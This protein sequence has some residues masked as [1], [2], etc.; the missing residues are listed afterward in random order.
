MIRPTFEDRCTVSCGILHPELTY[1]MKAG[2]LNPRR[3]LFTPPGLHAFPE[4]L[5]K[6]LL[7][8]LAYAREWCSDNE[9]IVVYGKKRHVSTD[10]PRKRV[11]SILQE[12][13]Q[14]IVRVQGDYG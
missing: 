13:D 2:F 7:K 10:E 1:L 11:D 3:I 14:G 6:H 8:R 12:A 5:E 4:R 9:I